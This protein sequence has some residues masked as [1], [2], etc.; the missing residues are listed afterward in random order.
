VE[1]PL[2]RQA[3]T[4]EERKLQRL[5]HLMCD[6]YDMTRDDRIRLTNAIIEALNATERLDLQK[7]DGN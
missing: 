2:A 4:E 7:S 6:V 5:L 3:K 1:E